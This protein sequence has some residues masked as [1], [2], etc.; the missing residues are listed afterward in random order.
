M[1][2][3]FSTKGFDNAGNHFRGAAL[4]AQ[5]HLHQRECVAAPPASVAFRAEY[6]RKVAASAAPRRGP[7]L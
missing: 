4:A 1:R 2:R 3:S 7:A 6:R 5:T